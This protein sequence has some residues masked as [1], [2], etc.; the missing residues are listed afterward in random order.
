LLAAFKPKAKLST[1]RWSSRNSI[2]CIS[3]S[4]I[5]TNPISGSLVN[6]KLISGNWVI[7]IV[8]GGNSVICCN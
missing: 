8:F 3:G 1:S 7:L 6:T 4:S 5:N 2:N